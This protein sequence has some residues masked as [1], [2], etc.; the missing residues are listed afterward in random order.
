MPVADPFYSIVRDTEAGGV[1]V[2]RLSG[3]LDINA[4]DDLRAAALA[5]VAEAKAVV[6]DLDATTF[7]DSEA[8]G[9]LIE[10][11]DAA[12]DAGVGVRAVNAHGMVHRVLDVA[13][14]L[15]LFDA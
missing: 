4:R 13:G 14:V 15:E 2:L 7:L 9:A 1:A 12:R 8:M 3:E 11:I 5:A 6:I 10:G